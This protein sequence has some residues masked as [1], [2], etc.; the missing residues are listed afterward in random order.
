MTQNATLIYTT[1]A[2]PKYCP[3]SAKFA[4]RNESVVVAGCDDTTQ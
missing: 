4:S 1:A 2:Y 3:P